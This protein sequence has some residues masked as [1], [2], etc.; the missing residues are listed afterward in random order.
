M[1][2]RTVTMQNIQRVKQI[3]RE[4][5]ELSNR[6]ISE[7]VNR[8]VSPTTVLRILR[9]EY[10][11]AIELSCSENWN[12]DSVPE[13]QVRDYRKISPQKLIRC[14]LCGSEQLRHKGT[15]VSDEG[16]TL[17]YLCGK[18]GENMFITTAKYSKDGKRY[19]K[20][21]DKTRAR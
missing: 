17:R 5:P 11:D 6:T 19:I 15:L 1:N 2:C 21:L 16:L 9:G 13:R 8:Q 4:H 3:K 12:V 7:L 10:D 18:C 20:K 14:P